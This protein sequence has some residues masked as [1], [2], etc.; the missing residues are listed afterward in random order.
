MEVIN[1]RDI[2][3]VMQETKTCYHLFDLQWYSPSQRMKHIGSSMGGCVQFRRNWFELV[4][5]PTLHELDDLGDIM[6]KQEKYTLWEP[7]LPK[8]VMI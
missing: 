5:C 2:Y 1:D 6:P 3:V 4:D 7:N 8:E